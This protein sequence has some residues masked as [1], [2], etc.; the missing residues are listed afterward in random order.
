VWWCS[1]TRATAA[2][3]MDVD[4]V[5]ISGDG[6]GDGDGDSDDG[7]FGGGGGGG[8]G[9]VDHNVAVTV[10]KVKEEAVEEPSFDEE[11]YNRLCTLYRL[12]YDAADT[13]LPEGMQ[14]RR[15]KSQP[16]IAAYPK[17]QAAVQAA[18][19]RGERRRVM[20]IL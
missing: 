19:K 20:T 2:G 10:V 7:F 16:R 6:R 8:G 12:P 5:V 13:S 4:A 1:T 15:R 14:L 9:T 11:Q 17:V 18:E 3:S